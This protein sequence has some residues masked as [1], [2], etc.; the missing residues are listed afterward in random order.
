MLVYSRIISS[1]TSAPESSQPHASS[2]LRR[3]TDATFL[4]IMTNSTTRA[5]MANA[6]SASCTCRG[7]LVSIGAFAIDV[8]DVDAARRQP[9]SYKGD[10]SFGSAA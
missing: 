6:V 9:G 1:D 2:G 8:A 4:S 10:L 3:F 5:S 7:V